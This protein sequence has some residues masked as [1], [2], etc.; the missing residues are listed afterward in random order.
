VW[1]DAT[2]QLTAA[3]LDELADHPAAQSASNLLSAILFEFTAYPQLMLW[4]VVPVEQIA[5]RLAQAVQGG[6]RTLATDRGCVSASLSVRDYPM[7]RHCIHLALVSGGDSTWH[8]LRL[9][10]LAY[11]RDNGTEGDYWLRQAFASYRGDSDLDE[12]ALLV[13]Y[14]TADNPAETPRTS[15][16][17][18]V[19]LVTLA[20]AQDSAQTLAFFEQLSRLSNDGDRPVFS[21]IAEFRS[22]SYW[23]FGFIGCVSRI[24]LNSYRGL[25][26]RTTR[27]ATEQQPTGRP[28][29]ANI[30]A[31]LFHRWDTMTGTPVAVVGTRLPIH[32]GRQSAASIGLRVWGGEEKVALSDQVVEVTPTENSIAAFS[33]PIQR[34]AEAWSLRVP[35]GNGTAAWAS[36]DPGPLP[37]PPGGL[38]ISDL[39]LA[40][41]ATSGTYA[42]GRDTVLVPIDSTVTREIPPVL[43]FQVRTNGA[44]DARMGIAITPWSEGDSANAISLM[45]AIHLD[46]GVSHLQRTIDLSRLP[47]GEYRLR[48]EITS[49]GSGAV[50]AGEMGFFLQ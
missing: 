28:L 18:A 33:V 39:I 23:G 22:L 4:P 2:R 24:R 38:Q 7:A 26:Q 8:S 43:D 47:K 9:A 16:E 44:V 10:W 49:V 19:A 12:L 46:L 35:L 11:R 40:D 5:Y 34:R 45:E 32:P 15:R 31:R 30:D 1:T 14:L 6:V 37:E 17:S 3:V 48:V 50:T 25:R 13:R 20:Q 29:R 42:D 36:A 21:R 41:P 27:C